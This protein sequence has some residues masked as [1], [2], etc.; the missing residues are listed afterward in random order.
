M[1]PHDAA[2]PF[3]SPSPQNADVRRYA[4]WEGVLEPRASAIAPRAPRRASRDTIRNVA[5][6]VRAA[7]AE[8]AAGSLPPRERERYLLD[9]LA[10]RRAPGRP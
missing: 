7:L 1:I 5:A 3:R 4:R 8:R 10:D 6:R 2:A 9:T